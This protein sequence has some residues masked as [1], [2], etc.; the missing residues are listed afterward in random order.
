MLTAV[1]TATEPQ[2]A[3]PNGMINSTQTFMFMM[4]DLDVPPAN[5]TTKRRVLL[6]AMETG[7]RPTQQRAS[8]AASI[9]T[10]TETGPA[11]YLPP[12]PPATDTMAHRY[13]QL[14]FEQPTSLKVRASDFAN[15]QARINFDVEKFMAANNVKA[16]IAANFFR[17][18][19]RANSTGTGSPTGTGGNTR[20]STVPFTGGA[21]GTSDVSFVLLGLFG[22]AA[23]LTV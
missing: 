20:N 18:D 4:L 6:H 13:V 5:G 14:L 11:S 23:M 19:G 12:G 15:T 2:I 3:L 7:F 8:G 1:V 9:L 22:A 16:P 10:T 17:V 21:A